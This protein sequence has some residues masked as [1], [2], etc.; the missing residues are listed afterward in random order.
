MNEVLDYF[1][2][3]EHKPIHRLAFLAGSIFI[4]WIIEGAIP[5]VSLTYK[6]NKQKHAAVNFTFTLFHLIIH[7]ALAVLVVKACDW[8]MQH[9]FGIVHWLNFPVWGIVVFGILSMDF[10]GGWLVHIVEHKVPLFWRIHLLHHTDNNVDVTTGLRHH[11]LEAFLR[12]VFFFGGIIITGLPIY[13]VMI[14]QTIMSVFTMF[15][16]ANIR[17]PSKVDEILSLVFVSPNMHK[18]HHHYK[19]P[20]TDSNYGTAFSIW[21]RLFGTFREMN[22]ADIHY[23]LDRYFDNERD[24]EFSAL[25]KSPFK[26]GPK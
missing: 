4:L 9:Q 3:L 5:L 22:P 2:N 15:T 17:L 25:I 6:K 20:F 8:C 23:G 18:V 14:A 13:A 19:Q 16:H 26:K 11:P 21:D 10:F 7:A 24:E 12:W 1:N